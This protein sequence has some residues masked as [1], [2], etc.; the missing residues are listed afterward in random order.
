MVLHVGA[1]KAGDHARVQDDIAA[2]AAA[3]HVGG[4]LLKV[5]L[6]TG[7]LGDPDAI[8]DASRISSIVS[9]VCTCDPV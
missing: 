7:E 3:C 4:A 2:V 1:L 9:G 8:R 5:I 6:E